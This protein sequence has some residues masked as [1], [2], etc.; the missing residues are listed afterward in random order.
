MNVHVMAP[1][2]VAFPG[3]FFYQGMPS[4]GLS[5]A[6]KGV[7]AAAFPGSK[8]YQGMP[9]PGLSLAQK[10]VPAVA[11]PGRKN[12]QGMPL[13]AHFDPLVPHTANLLAISTGRRPDADMQSHSMGP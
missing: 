10:G 7:P 2:A 13:P 4:P 1:L 5:L 6:H 12:Y 11:F 8:N 9:S 3:S